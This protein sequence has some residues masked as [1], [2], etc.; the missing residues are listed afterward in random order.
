MLSE[1]PPAR[2]GFC[3]K[4]TREPACGPVSSSAVGVPVSTLRR[5]EKRPELGRRLE[6]R[7]RELRMRFPAWEGEDRGGGA[8]SLTPSPK[9]TAARP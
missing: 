4:P 9:K 8:E 5:W 2:H 3:L 1:T 6:S 7:V